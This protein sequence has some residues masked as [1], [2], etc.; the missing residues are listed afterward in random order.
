MSNDNR[1][2]ILKK[3]EGS[4]SLEKNKALVRK[5]NEALNKK[6]LTILDDV[7]ASNYVDHTN[8]LRGREDVKR[9]YTRIFK[10]FPVWHRIIEDIIAEGD[11]VWFRVKTI[12]ATVSAKEIEVTTVGIFRIANAKAVE[13]W[14]VPKVTGE[15]YEKLL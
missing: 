14:T 13:G 8:L 12:G 4:M 7:V 2:L 9:F 5:L 6:D 3:G 1:S 11:K 15:F 10:D